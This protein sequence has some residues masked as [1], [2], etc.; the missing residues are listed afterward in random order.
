MHI[1]LTRIPFCAVPER[2]SQLFGE[3]DD[4]NTHMNLQKTSALVVRLHMILLTLN[5][6]RQY[7]TEGFLT[8]AS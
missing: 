8:P 2:R 3:T 4:P 1:S 6:A 5:A 7:F